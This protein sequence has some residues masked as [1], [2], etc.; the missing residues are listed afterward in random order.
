MY[1]Y[2]FTLKYNYASDMGVEVFIIIDTSDF[3]IIIIIN[4][5]FFL[6]I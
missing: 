5:I 4:A 1:Y 6:L 2:L 3:N